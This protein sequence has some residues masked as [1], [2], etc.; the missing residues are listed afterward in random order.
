[1]GRK[2]ADA[3]ANLART[4]QAQLKRAESLGRSLDERM[5]KKKLAS[6]EWTLDEDFRRDFAAV[7]TAIQHA[8]KSLVIALESGKKN[9]GS[10]TEAQLDA[11]W[12]AEVV[13]AAT[14]ISD[15]D[16]DLM[17]AARAKR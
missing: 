2:P 4:A 1:M 6:D 11:Q 8:G 7:T 17:V 5:K 15:A 3:F 9:L 12:S 16:W 14:S 10:L 13:R